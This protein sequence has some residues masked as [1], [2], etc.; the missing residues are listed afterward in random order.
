MHVT[1]KKTLLEYGAQ[2]IWKIVPLNPIRYL[3]HKAIITNL[4]GIADQHNIKHN[5]IDIIEIPEEEDSEQ[6]IQNLFEKMMV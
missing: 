1:H 3:L 4:G 2:V 5:N 6:R